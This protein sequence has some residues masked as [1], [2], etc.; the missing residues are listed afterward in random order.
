VFKEAEAMLVEL[1][2]KPQSCFSICKQYGISKT[3]RDAP[4]PCV[5][6]G[7][8]RTDLNKP[9]ENPVVK[10][11]NPVVEST[12]S[13]AVAIKID[14]QQIFRCGLANAKTTATKLAN[15]GA[16]IPTTPT[17]H[18]HSGSFAHPP[19]ELLV[20][21][22]IEGASINYSKTRNLEFER[23]RAD[24]YNGIKVRTPQAC[25]LPTGRLSGDKKHDNDA[26]A[27]QR[28]IKDPAE[29][30]HQ[31]PSSCP[32]KYRPVQGAEKAEVINERDTSN[33]KHRKATL[34]DLE[35]GVIDL[36]N[37]HASELKTLKIML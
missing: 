9:Q 37:M 29:G 31:P 20:A 4:Y 7:G 28:R 18:S 25:P 6:V 14:P 1:G 5:F 17:T 3:N 2:V 8:L 27:T 21:E 36:D 10:E 32:T 26:A 33:T 13:P 19:E 12:R 22:N 16:T 23:K 11:E 30:S 24:H 15:D 34:A 35:T